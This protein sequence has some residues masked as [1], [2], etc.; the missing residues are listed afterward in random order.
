MEN[1]EKTEGTVSSMES[2]T[3][4]PPVSRIVSVSDGE[5]NDDNGHGVMEELEDLISSLRFT[6]SC[7]QLQP[8]CKER[9]KP[10]LIGT[11]ARAIHC[12][13]RKSKHC[14]KCLKGLT[15]VPWVYHLKSSL[16]PPSR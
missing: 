1:I 7:Y 11:K 15:A 13:L 6:M 16:K 8:G 9:K 3:V 5:G 14:L 4:P 12:L 10:T 2:L